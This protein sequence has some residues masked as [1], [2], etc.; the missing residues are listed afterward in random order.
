[1]LDVAR[2][3]FVSGGTLPLDSESYIERK[4]DRQLLEDL[5]A[6]RYCYVLNSRQ[7]GK[8]SLSVRTIARLGQ[9]GVRTVFIDL[10]QIGGRNVQATQWYAGLTGEVGRS[11]GLSS[12]VLAYFKS[13]S[14][15]S[16]MQRFFGAIREVVL[17]EIGEPLVIFIDEIDGTRNLPFDTDEF[18]AGIRECYNRRVQDEPSRRLTFCL[19]GVA[20]PND[21]IRDS[22][23]TPFNIGER[24][25]LQDFSLEDV[26]VFS[27]ALGANGE[28]LARRVHYWTNG[29]PFLTQSLCQEIA[30]DTRIQSEEAVDLLVKRLFFGANSVDTNL[31]LADVANRVLNDPGHQGD[32]D[33]F[34]ADLLSAYDLARRGGTIKDDEANRIPVVLKLSG[35]MRAE[36][37]RLVVRN[38][39]YGHIFDKTWIQ[40]NM[41]GQELVRQRVSFRR[42]LLR[43]IVVAVVLGAVIG[44]LGLLAT[45]AR[46]D[47]LAAKSALDY[48]LYVAD[49]NGLKLFEL[50]GDSTRMAAVLERTKHSAHRNFEWNFWLGRL[51]DSPEEYTLDYSAP[52]KLEQGLLSQDGR[53]VCIEDQLL[54]T[55]FVVERRTNHVLGSAYLPYRSISATSVGILSFD[56][57][58]CPRP[59]IE[60]ATGKVTSHIGVPGFRLMGVVNRDQADFVATA[61]LSIADDAKRVIDVWDLKSGKMTFRLTP[62]TN[63]YV[64]LDISRDGRRIVYTEQTPDIPTKHSSMPPSL[65]VWDTV[66]NREIDRCPFPNPT[67]FGTMSESGKLIAY[68]DEHHLAKIRDVDQR[69]E[70]YST[71]GTGEDVPISISLAPDDKSMVCITSDG[72]A[73]IREVPTGRLLAVKTNLWRMAPTNGHSQWVGSSSTVRILD[74]SR[75]GQ[76][77]I[78]SA[79]KVSRD[80]LG[81]FRFTTDGSA[82]VSRVS[83]P[84]L[85]PLPS[86]NLPKGGVNLTYSGLWCMVEE[87]GKPSRI[88][89]IG[90]KTSSIELPFEL[91]NFACGINPDLLIA[92]DSH[93]VFMGI[94]GH[95]HKIVWQ[96]KFDPTLE[97]IWL[98][99]D[100][101]RLIGSTWDGQIGSLDPRTGQVIHWSEAHNLR[102]T[103]L[104]FS[105]DGR[106]FVTGGA[107]GRA[108]VWD[109]TTLKKIVEL[110]GNAAQRI[111]CADI[112][113]DG[114]RVATC[115]VTGAWQIWDVATGAELTEI[116]ASNLPLT[117]VV[118]SADGRKLITSGDDGIVRSWVGLDRNPT[119]RIPLPPGALKNVGL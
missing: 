79:T 96:K 93:R 6:G 115:N 87:P 22:A 71:L 113:P 29:Q 83:D 84:D 38:R 21:L 97:G 47:A 76:G 108:I 12:Q 95:N 24:I 54:K 20:V 98:S 104:R 8:S 117:S 11:L 32:P 50:S 105:R 92:M 90:G 51:H 99:P 15:L 28:L 36:D 9:R 64:L 43:G 25:P 13:H 86:I 27:R 19:L 39:I 103:A 100:S 33:K 109:S 16:P 67:S 42:G 74:L 56:R 5:S 112:S 1:M 119:I 77:I 73:S 53:E 81:S 10:T 107:D 55:A 60:I 102:L 89:S 44:T 26:R 63:Q 101:T 85:K 116:R 70:I 3:F 48:E 75:N 17:K 61:E 65:V 66:A 118:F 7:M 30:L 23:T 49:M 31:N 69:K 82:D 91:Q 18:F 114:R 88:E 45:R 37:A 111:D 46:A 110:R 80:G 68:W 62:S 34:R 94:A 40:A 52:G 72:L 58:D 78:G 14:D 4:A 35:L 41:P 2:E 57:G 106:H 59:V